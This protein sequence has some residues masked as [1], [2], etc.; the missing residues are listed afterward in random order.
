VLS[1]YLFCKSKTKKN[2]LV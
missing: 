1:L 2:V